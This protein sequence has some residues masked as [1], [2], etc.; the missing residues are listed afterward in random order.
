MI[1]KVQHGGQEDACLPHVW[2][3]EAFVLREFSPII[4]VP[5]HA[6]EVSAVTAVALLGQLVD[7]VL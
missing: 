6:S 2:E 3:D 7:F 1:R 5:T 4:F